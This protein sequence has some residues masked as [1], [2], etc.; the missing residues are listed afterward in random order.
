MHL[1]EYYSEHN[2]SFS[3]SQLQASNFAKFVANDYNNIHDVNSRR[4]CVPGDLLFALSL[5]KFGL[6]PNMKIEFKD[7]VKNDIS[8]QFTRIDDEK[9]AITGEEEQ[10]FMTL[11]A[12]GEPVTEPALITKVIQDYVRFSGENF[13]TLLVPLLKEKALMLSPTRALA[14][15]KNMSINLH[16]RELSNPTIAFAGSDIELQGK[17]ATVILKFNFIENDQIVGTGQKEMILSGL[18]PYQQEV[19]DGVI[20]DYEALKTSTAH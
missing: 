4:F 14:M 19:V 15:Y 20:R 2:G 10:E 13:P 17:R 11:T 9:T 18:V 12:S 3:F 8:L 1:K 5:T 7:M 6:Y 16:T